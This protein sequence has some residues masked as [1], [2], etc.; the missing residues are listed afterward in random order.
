MATKFTWSFGK[1]RIMLA[2]AT[3]T[4]TWEYGKTTRRFKYVA[5]TAT[6]P[7]SEYN[8]NIRRRRR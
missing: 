7:P 5:P 4:V 3:P 8:T 6:T 2:G 1:A